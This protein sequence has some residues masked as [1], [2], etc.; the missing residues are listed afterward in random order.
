VTVVDPALTSARRDASIETPVPA[1]VVDPG[2]GLPRHGTYRGAL[3]AADLSTLRRGP[4]A[5][6]TQEKRWIYVAIVREPWM[7]AL[8]LVDLG[9]LQTAFGFAYHEGKGLRVDMSTIPGLPG[10]SGVRQDG[11]HRIDA[12]VR[13]PGARFAVHER[14]GEPVLEVHASTR[15]LELRCSLDLSRAAPALTAIA[16]VRGGTVDV[17]EKRVLAPVRGAAL[18]RGERV[19]LD[20][21][22]GGFDLTVG[23][24]ARETRWNWGFFMGRTESGEPIA[25]N[26]VQGFV[27]APECALFGTGGHGTGGHGTGSLHA[28]S[29]GRFEYDKARLADPWRVRTERGECDLVFTPGAVHSEALDLGVLRSRFVQPIGAFQGTI[30]RGTETLRIAHALGVVEDQDVRW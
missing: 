25:M 18:I 19:D 29:E 24:L 23:L 17:T 3:G 21:G 11:V 20:G 8:A 14:R 15:D 1:S 9:Y 27:G 26:L 16:P 5:A 22:V 10:L 7:I 28:L 12:R 4:L 30:Q 2:S 6:L 13:A